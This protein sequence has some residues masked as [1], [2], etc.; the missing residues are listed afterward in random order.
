MKICDKKRS[1][2]HTYF[3]C[4]TYLSELSST[5]KVRDSRFQQAE[6]ETH[7]LI[8]LCWLRSIWNWNFVA[9]WLV[10]THWCCGYQ[11]HSNLSSHINLNGLFEKNEQLKSDIMGDG[12]AKSSFRFQ[13]SKWKEVIK[14]AQWDQSGIKINF[15]VIS[16]EF[17]SSLWKGYY[18]D[19]R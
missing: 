7:V 8:M 10:L 17:C 3:G 5:K 6:S 11:E 18:C 1:F 19:F 12:V 13:F 4:W 16:C 2:R 9:F 14:W 15:K